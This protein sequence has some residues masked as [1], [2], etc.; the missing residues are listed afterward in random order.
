MCAK[1]APTSQKAALRHHIPAVNVAFWLSL[2]STPLRRG[3]E[4]V[5]KSHYIQTVNHRDA[6]FLNALRCGGLCTK[7]QALTFI[8]GNRL[9]NFV[10]DKTLEK[11]SFIGRG[12]QRQEAYRVTEQGKEW[13]KQHIPDLA[14]RKFYRS[15]GTE[16]DLK[17]MDKICALSREQRET[18]RCEAEIRD[19]FRERLQMLLESRDYERYEQLY[20]ALQA[21]TISMPD[22]CYGVDQFYE[23]VTSNYGQVEVEAKIEAVAAVGG[24]LETERI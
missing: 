3:G 16:H 10:L 17:L 18:M 11:C 22:L 13:I 14:E 5:R 12:G 20:N 24:T 19:E 9:K 15:N 8:S 2:H 7:Q 6:D 1:I 21:H 4:N 23:V